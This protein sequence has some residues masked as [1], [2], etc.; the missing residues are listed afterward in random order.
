MNSFQALLYHQEW[1]NVLLFYFLCVI[2][3]N[4]KSEEI[5]YNY[6]Q[7]R[8]LPSGK[9]FVLLFNGIFIYENDFS[10]NEQIYQFK[11]NQVIHTEED[12]N[13]T[14]LSEI[15]LENKYYIACLVKNFLYLYDN[16]KSS[17]VNELMKLI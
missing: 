8:N 10:K 4:C 13:I 11:G 14:V 5:S 6:T 9:F 16:D 17:I 1:V 12:M 3:I 2:S 7:I 15:E